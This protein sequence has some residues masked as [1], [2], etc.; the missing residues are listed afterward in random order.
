MRSTETTLVSSA[1]TATSFLRLVEQIVDELGQAT[2]QAQVSYLMGRMFGA[3]H[4]LNVDLQRP[5]LADQLRAAFSP[6]AEISFV[7]S[8]ALKKPYGYA[9]D[10]VALE[11]LY[12]N[13][14]NPSSTA[15]GQFIDRWLLDAQLGIGVRERKNMLSAFIERK[16]QAHAVSGKS[17]RLLS[18]AAGSARELRDLPETVLQN[19]DATL[20]DQDPRSLEFACRHLPSSVTQMNRNALR[21]KASSFPQPFDLVYSFGFFDYLSDDLIVH[22]LNLCRSALAPCGS[23]IFP[24]KIDSKF[25]H[26]FYDVF[27]DWRFVK[28][29]LADGLRL[30]SQ[31]GLDV[32]ELL[33]TENESVVFYHCV[34]RQI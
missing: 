17:L 3:Q 20:V 9:G 28:R 4:L 25:R 5:E 26:W 29:E 18:L 23:V 30:A 16:V 7:L 11:M 6:L 27:L 8:W 32:V 22:S 34:P 13:R 2:S 33:E 14:V 12:D 15:E 31:A 1:T 21:L 24:L 19:L 10:F